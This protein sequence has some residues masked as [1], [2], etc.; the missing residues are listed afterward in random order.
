MAKTGHSLI[1]MSFLFKLP[2][3]TF[4]QHRFN[5]NSIS[6]PILQ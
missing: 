2:T 1:H 6:R 3:H 5:H 4:I